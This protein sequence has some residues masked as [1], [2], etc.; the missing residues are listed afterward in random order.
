MI[1]NCY[2][3]TPARKRVLKQELLTLLNSK[4]SQYEECENCRF[5]SILELD[6]ENED[7]CNWIGAN[8]KL[9]CSG[10]PS[11]KCRPFVSRILSEAGKHYNIK[12]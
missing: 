3:E 8:V 10:E 12:K 2:K 5:V 7:G 11:E 6:E 1:E 4:L 9:I